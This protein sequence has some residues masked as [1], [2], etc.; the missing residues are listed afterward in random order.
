MSWEVHSELE[1]LRKFILSLPSPD[2]E[3]I[4]QNFFKKIHPHEESLWNLE[5]SIPVFQHLDVVTS[6]SIAV[7]I[8]TA[9]EIYRHR[10]CLG[11]PLKEARDPSEFKIIRDS[12]CWKTYSEIGKMSKN[13]AISLRKIFPRRVNIGITSNNCFEFMISDFACAF[14]NFVSVGLHTTYE[15]EDLIKVIKNSEVVAIIV[16]GTKHAQIISILPHAPSISHVISMHREFNETESSQIRKCEITPHYLY[17]MIRDEEHGKNGEASIP[18]NEGGG[19]NDGE[20]SIPSNDGGGEYGGA[21]DPLESRG[22][23]GVPSDEGGGNA[24]GACTLSLEDRCDSDPF[25][26]LYTSGSTG[27]PKG[28]IYTHAIMRD[29]TGH[30]MYLEPLV[31][32]SYI[33]LSHSTDRMRIWETIQNGGRV[34][35]CNY[36]HTN[37]NE[38]ETI[39]KTTLLN[40]FNQTTNGV[41]ELIS[42]LTPLRP[43]IFVAP[44]NIWNGIYSIYSNLIMVKKNQIGLT[45]ATEFTRSEVRKILGDRVLHLATGGSPTSELVMKWIQDTWPEASFVESYGCTECGGITQNGKPMDGVEVDLIDRP[46]FGMVRTT[47]TDPSYQARVGELKG[48][49]GIN[50]E[51][52][53]YWKNSTDTL[54]SFVDGWFLT[55]DICSID[56]DGTILV[57]DRVKSLVVLPLGKAYC[58]NRLESIYSSLSFARHVCVYNKPD[59]NDLLLIISVDGKKLHDWILEKHKQLKATVDDESNL[60]ESEE[61]LQQEI[62]SETTALAKNQNFAI[63][64]MPKFLFLT[65][66]EWTF[67]NH[68]LTISFKVIRDN[69]VKHYQ[70]QIL[71]IL[72]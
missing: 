64:E 53:G 6:S 8:D 40:S 37:W 55:G 65:L 4:Y 46:E 36:K 14:A 34:G 45:L 61:R 62:L 66:D 22:E 5:Y 27:V 18:S 48:S 17:H 35:F 67:E 39:K 9:F 42:D 12:F 60:F 43:T 44:P 7:R 25:T 16:G 57:L 26:I 11:I 21:H 19:G 52:G 72:K 56:T 50:A 71:K 54:T 68:L 23:A 15:D 58:T 70:E 3:E 2:S 33:P 49:S 13:F 69:V 63:Y 10:P 47:N 24:G 31:N 32:V 30:A 1:K 51:Y 41:E 59:Q 38:H 28:V 20:A 29:D